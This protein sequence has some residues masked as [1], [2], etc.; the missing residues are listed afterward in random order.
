[1]KT[2]CY[3]VPVS[4]NGAEPAPRWLFHYII[5]ESLSGLH[6]LSRTPSIDHSSTHLAQA[7]QVSFRLKLPVLS[8]ILLKRKF[9]RQASRQFQR[10]L[11]PHT[12]WPT[13][14]HSLLVAWLHLKCYCD[15]DSPK[16]QTLLPL[17][18]KAAASLAKTQLH[19]AGYP[20]KALNSFLF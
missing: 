16:R 6:T 9:I 3:N 1:M 7:L 19:L 10:P 11:D 4:R 5:T 12:D 15:S 14:C 8:Y 18:S 2:A 20:E 17:L 13:R